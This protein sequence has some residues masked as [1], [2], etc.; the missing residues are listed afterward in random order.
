[1]LSIEQILI[2]QKLTD[3]LSKLPIDSISELKVKIGEAIELFESQ[4]L[5]QSFDDLADPIAAKMR[6]YITESHRLLRLLPM[7]IMFIAAAR[8]PENLQQRRQAYQD[9]LNLLIKYC[10]A[11]VENGKIDNQF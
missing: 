6:S 1:M 4:I 5:T 9:K 3:R 8:N 7:D 11:V 2:W 10:Q